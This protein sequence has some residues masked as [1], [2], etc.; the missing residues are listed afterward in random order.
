MVENCVILSRNLNF[1]VTL[2][3][4]VRVGGLI[5]V[6]TRQNFAPFS[7]LKT[8]HSS[9]NLKYTC[10]KNSL[11]IRHLSLQDP[12]FGCVGVGVKG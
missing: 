2:I 3:N 12:F 4:F 7:K 11:K 6:D 9:V 5:A 1:N 10:A 8:Q